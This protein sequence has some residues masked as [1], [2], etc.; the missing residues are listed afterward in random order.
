MKRTSVIVATLCT[1]AVCF[2]ACKENRFKG[3][4]KTETGLYYKFKERN[5]EGRQP[6][7]GD[8]VFMT[9]S[10]YSDNDSI[11]P[12][13]KF[14]NREIMDA[15]TASVH[16]G[17]IYEAYAL[18]K[19]GEEAEFVIKADSFF[20]AMSGQ[21]PPMVKSEDV[22][23]FTIKMNKIKSMD[24]FEQEEE[25]AIKNYITENNITVE[26]T[27][28]GLYYIETEKGKGTKVEEGKSVKIHYTGKFLDGTVFDSSV[29]RGEPIAFT[30]GTDPMIAGFVEGVQL[31]KKG[32]KATLILP[33]NIAYGKSHPS[34]P[35]PP[36]TPLLFEVEIVEVK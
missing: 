22:L 4:E 17:D 19:E 13:M 31:M 20:F 8:F 35:I 25:A 33:S 12:F 28:S 32:G 15:L 2:S 29:E 30:V 5:P 16:Q 1:I 27:E 34:A 18:L 23:F 11:N 6:Q 7:L 10:C 21:V 36:F 26:P 24:D 9:V 14:E 3:Y